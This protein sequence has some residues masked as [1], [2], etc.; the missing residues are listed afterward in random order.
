MSTANSHDRFRL[1]RGVWMALAIILVAA[2]GLIAGR[3]HEP[4]QCPRQDCQTLIAPERF[5]AFFVVFES[6]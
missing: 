6:V 4:L 5:D 2:S 1:A 3:Q